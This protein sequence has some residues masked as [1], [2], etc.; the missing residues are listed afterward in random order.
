MIR[1]DDWRSDLITLL[2]TF[3][4][5]NCRSAYENATPTGGFDSSIIT[6]PSFENQGTTIAQVSSA[7]VEKRNWMPRLDS[8]PDTRHARA[9][10]HFLGSE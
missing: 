4:R 7:G 2:I 1:A 10:F 3:S 9:D 8:C 6:E 5:Q